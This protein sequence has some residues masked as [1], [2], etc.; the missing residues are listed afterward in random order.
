[1]IENQFNV[2]K[3]RIS[4]QTIVWLQPT[5]VRDVYTRCR[6]LSIITAVRDAIYIYILFMNTSC[7]P[8][9]IYIPL[10]V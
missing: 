7:C 10:V 5:D 6:S 4:Y 1:M 3:H 8:Y 2:Q 9:R